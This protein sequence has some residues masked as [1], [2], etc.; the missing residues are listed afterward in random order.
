MDARVTLKEDPKVDTSSTPENAVVATQGDGEDAVTQVTLEPAPVADPSVEPATEAPAAEPAKASLE[1]P[2]VGQKVAG[3]ETPAAEAPKAFE[4]AVDLEALAKEYVESGGLSEKTYED[5]KAK[6]F[7]K[8]V[9]DTY[10]EGRKAQVAAYNNSLAESVGGTEAVNKVFEWAAEA[11]SDT[12]KA[13]VNK[14]LASFDA[15]QAKLVLA[16]LKA[17]YEGAVGREPALVQGHAAPTT[18]TIKPYESN[19]QMVEDMRNPKYHTDPA[20]RK[21]VER[22]IAASM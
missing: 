21:M 11:L 4:E 7:S 16:G 1:A 6:G 17:R 5:Y 18:A 14:A 10:I 22:R 20:F 19:A 8:E 3:D 15:D 2:Q 12:E 13:A 9:V